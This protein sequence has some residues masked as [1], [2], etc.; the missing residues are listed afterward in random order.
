MLHKLIA[1]PFVMLYVIWIATPL[2]MLGLD[3][4]PVNEWAF[5]LWHGRTIRRRLS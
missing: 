3:G 4:L 5:A 1:Y 2:R